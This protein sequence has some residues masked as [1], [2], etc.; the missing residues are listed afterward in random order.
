MVNHLPMDQKRFET[1]YDQWAEAMYHFALGLAGHEDI[2]KDLVQETLIKVSKDQNFFI[3]AH[4]ERAYLFKMIRNA[5]I[6]H[7]RKDSSWK[8]RGERWGNDMGL[9]SPANDP[10]EQEF[11]KWL[12]QALAELPE[13]QRSV[14]LMHLWEGMTFAEIG[15]VCGISSN[16]AASRYRYA[17][18]KM[19]DQL[20]PLYEEIKT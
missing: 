1:L 6:D 2:A 9:I 13:K 3:K 14:A 8:K 7:V 12:E 19:R 10:D 18:D 20:R 4:D 5:L 16:T 11:V 17:L 15:K